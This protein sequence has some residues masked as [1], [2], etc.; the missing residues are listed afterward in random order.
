MTTTIQWTD[1]TWNPIRARNLDSGQIGW[2]CERVSQGCTNCY[3]EHRNKGFFQLGTRLPYMRQSRDKV[4][5]FIDEETLTQPLRWKKPRMIFVCSMTD[6]FGEWHSDEM[7]DRVFAVMALCPQHTFQV[8]T[9]RAERMRQYVSQT[10][11][12]LPC[13]DT[14]TRIA[15][16]LEDVAPIEL[17]KRWPL[18]NVW[19]GVSV[20]D[21]RWADERI[22]HLLDAPAAVRF[23]SCEPLLSNIGLMYY[24]YTRIDTN[25]GRFPLRRLN[26]V[27]VGGES[28][29]HARP[30]DLAYARG[31]LAQCKAAGVACFVKQLGKVPVMNERDWRLLSPTPLLNPNNRAHAPDG[32]G[33]VPLYLS[34]RKG[35]AIEE[36]PEDLR[37]RE[38]PK[39]PYTVRT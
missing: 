21:Q 37:V 17:R 22:P 15:Y 13:T 39:T 19:L 10:S 26:W 4:E 33:K 23:L 31:I 27:I 28:G 2:H 11:C 16:R 14:I 5:I 38:F 1:E 32:S 34:D 36:W 25:D 20:E 30:F 8:L 6:L 29:S 9:K 35:G 7:I 12:G 3:A 18:P 24:L